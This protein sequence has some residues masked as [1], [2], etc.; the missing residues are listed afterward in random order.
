MLD[1]INMLATIIGYAVLLIVLIG[2]FAF[3]G[4]KLPDVV[5]EGLEYV[6]RPDLA[7]RFVLWYKHIIG[8]LDEDLIEAATKVSKWE[9]VEEE[10]K[11]IIDS[12][13]SS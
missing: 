13:R 10:L 7:I 1:P 9:N 3:L 12:Y 4:Y 6:G 2:V 8:S 5:S 11:P